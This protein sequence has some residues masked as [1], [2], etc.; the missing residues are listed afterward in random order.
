M[1]YATYSQLLEVLP[2]GATTDATALGNIL[3]RVSK[4]IDTYLGYKFEDA[5][6]AADRVFYGLG[7]P[8]LKIDW[9]DDDPSSGDVSMPSSFTVPTFA[10]MRDSIVGTLYLQTCDSD[11]RLYDNNRVGYGDGFFGIATP[12]IW[13][14][15]LPVTVNAAWGY[16]AIPDD[17]VDITLKLAMKDWRQTYAPSLPDWRED[18]NVPWETIKQM[19]DDRKATSDFT[20]GVG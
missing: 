5:S 3:T 2:D 17:I 7:T 13:P 16:A 11:G 4:R 1:A 12:T 10:V 9:T 6:T 19:L 8:L 14:Y 18:A 20:L 15:G